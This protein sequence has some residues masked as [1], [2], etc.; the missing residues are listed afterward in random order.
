MLYLMTNIHLFRKCG[1]RMAKRGFPQRL[2]KCDVCGKIYTQ[3]TAKQVRCA[4]CQKKFCSKRAKERRDEQLKATDYWAWVE[5]HD[6]NVC[7]KVKKCE[8]GLL[9][10]GIW[11][12]NYRE[13]VGH[14][15][16]CPVKDCTVFIRKGGRNAG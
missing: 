13:I 16:P 12:C 14:K 15:R 1:V 6:P 2:R 9:C 11:I 8:Y 4:E 3:K 7:R 10:G 5:K